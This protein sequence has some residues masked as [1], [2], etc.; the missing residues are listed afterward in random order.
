MALYDNLPS[1]VRHRIQDPI[2]Y[3]DVTRQGDG[4][5]T[6]HMLEHTNVQNGTA[7]VPIGGTAWSATGA[8]FNGASN[9]A[10]AEFSTVIS[11]FSAYRLVY[12]YSVFSDDEIGYFTAVGGNVAGAALAAVRAL[13]FDALK[14]ARWMSPDGAQFDDSMAQNYLIRL[15]SALR[16]EIEEQQVFGGDL[17]SWSDLQGEY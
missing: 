5:A 8:T 3:A 17:Q 6:R 4:T 11:A 7:Y 1:A 15:A 9:P 16:Q 12:N 10:Y 13:G 14:R 2:R